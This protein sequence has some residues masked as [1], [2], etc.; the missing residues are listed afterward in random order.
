MLR[1]HGG[2]AGWSDNQLLDM[3][4]ARLLQ[5]AEVAIDEMSR[6]ERNQLVNAAFVGYQ[7][8]ASQGALKSG[9]SFS[10]YLASLGLA[11]KPAEGTLTRE[12]EAAAATAARVAELFNAGPVRKE[13]E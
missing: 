4:Y 12:R 2:Y 8:A 7:M 11:D 5:A 13:T 3:P 10:K 9:M 6:V 1:T